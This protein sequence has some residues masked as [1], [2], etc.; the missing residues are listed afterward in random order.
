MESQKKTA[1]PFKSGAVAIVGRPNVGKS[2]LLNLLVKFKLSSISPKPQTTRHK[3]L[4]ILTG[5]NYQVAFLDTPGMPFKTNY[6]L[7][8]F[9]VARAL[10]AIRE[11]D[12]VALMVEPKPPADIEQRLIEEIKRQKKPAILIIN[13]IDVVRKPELL[14]IIK[15]YSRLY[16]FIEVAPVSALKMDGIDSL[17]DTIVK[18]LPEGTP[19]FPPDEVTDRPER[20]LVAE[21]IREAV[22]NIY[23]Q[24][25]PYAV[26]AE[27]EEFK[28]RSEEQGGKDF[29]RAIL[30]VERDSQKAIL[31]GRGGEKM[32]KIGERARQEIE[33][34]LGRSV[35]L[36]L[37]V[38]VYPK[39]RKDKA[40]L[41]RIGY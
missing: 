41:Q 7:D 2:T 8:R 40:F 20:F 12:M 33:T 9:L 37:W 6:E 5:D 25:V 39:W 17:I 30:Y 15:E 10:E 18:H 1:L 19:L 11:A 13:K 23:S 29:I 16:S 32:K 22:F 38:K 3:I 27:I 26:A 28:E 36:E 35:Y 14:P 21:I 24:E 34:L 4:G 31:I